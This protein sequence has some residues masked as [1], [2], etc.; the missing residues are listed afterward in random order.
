MQPKYHCSQMN[1]I[2]FTR[3]SRLLTMNGVHFLSESDVLLT[4][5]AQNQSLN[6]YWHYARSRLYKKHYAQTM[7]SLPV[8]VLAVCAVRMSAL[9]HTWQWL[10]YIKKTMRRL[11]A[12]FRC[13]SWHYARSERKCWYCANEWSLVLLKWALFK[14][15]LGIYIYIYI[16][17]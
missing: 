12:A 15:V 10:P 1:I 16:Y 4:L 2:G 7:R 17:V 9:V 5:P 8:Q 6:T 14:W 3:V 11:C 13:R